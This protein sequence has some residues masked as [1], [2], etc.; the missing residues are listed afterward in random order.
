MFSPVVTHTCIR[1]MLTLVAHS[2]MQLEHI[3]VSTAFLHGYLEEKIYLVQSKVF[4][5]PGCKNVV[6]KFKK[7]LYGLRL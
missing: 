6:Y 7:S 5:Y 4:S 1:T 2:G 3:D